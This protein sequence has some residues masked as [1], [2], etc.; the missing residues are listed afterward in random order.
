MSRRL[1]WQDSYGQVHR[2]KKAEKA[3][4]G[5]FTGPLRMVML[6]LVAMAL[7]TVLAS[8]H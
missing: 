4:P 3:R 1:Y 8:L 7:L 6:L 5:A 2:D